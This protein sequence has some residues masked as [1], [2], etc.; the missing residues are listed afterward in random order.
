[1][2]VMNTISTLVPSQVDESARGPTAFSH[3]GELYFL[4]SIFSIR[5]NLVI[6]NLL[7]ASAYPGEKDSDAHK[8]L[9]RQIIDAGTQVV[10]NLMEIE[11][12]KTFTPYQ[13]IML[14]HA[15]E[16]ISTYFISLVFRHSDLNISFDTLK[17]EKNKFSLY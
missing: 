5:F 15:K 13:D 9:T 14:Q 4:V 16:G 8:I 3:W 2:P 6:P 1:M 10:V 7:L 12:L 11:E 17:L